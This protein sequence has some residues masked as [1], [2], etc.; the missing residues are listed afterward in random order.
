MITG[1]GALTAVEVAR[2]VGI[3]PSTDEGDRTSTLRLACRRRKGDG[4]EEEEK[5][6]M[7]WEPMSAKPRAEEEDD[8]DIEVRHY[9]HALD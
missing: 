6:E 9:P 5:E 1:D 2:Q 3:I 4:E 8:Q 7:V